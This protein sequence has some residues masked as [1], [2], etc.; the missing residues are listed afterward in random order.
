VYGHLE[1]EELLISEDTVV[2]LELRSDYLKK[3]EDQIMNNKN[4]LILS[5]IVLFLMAMPIEEV[6]AAQISSP[7][8]SLEKFCQEY[9]KQTKNFQKKYR[10]VY[11]KNCLK[12]N[13][14]VAVPPKKEQTQTAPPSQQ[15]LDPKKDEVKPPQ[16]Q[17]E[18]KPVKKR[19]APIPQQPEVKPA[20]KKEPEIKRP[21]PVLR[22]PLPETKKAPLPVVKTQQQQAAA[23]L[24]IAAFKAPASAK[25]GE[26]ISKKIQL[27]I[28]NQGSG[29]ATGSAL[30]RTKGYTVYLVLSR[31]QSVPVNVATQAGKFQEDLLLKGGAKVKTED[32]GSGEQFSFPTT[33]VVIPKDT[34]AGNY[35]LCARI[36]PWNRVKEINE[37]N[38]LTCIAISITGAPK[39]ALT[40]SAVPGPK[41]PRDD[42][43]RSMPTATPNLDADF[44]A[45][46]RD[47]GSPVSSAIE[48][49][50]TRDGIESATQP[51]AEQIRRSGS[52][53]ELRLKPD[54]I[55][56]HVE[57]R[58]EGPDIGKLYIEVTALTLLP[59][60]TEAFHW[61]I[62]GLA[63]LSGY[64]F[65]TPPE[66]HG[67]F[68]EGLAT[69]DPDGIARIL[70]DGR[71]PVPESLDDPLNHH[72]VEITINED[73]AFIESNYQNNT[74]IIRPL[75][76]LRTD[77][78]TRS[79]PEYLLE[80]AWV[81]SEGSSWA[82]LHI[83]YTGPSRE[84]GERFRF[85]WLIFNSDY[86]YLWSDTIPLPPEPLHCTDGLPYLPVTTPGGTG[87]IAR[88]FCQRIRFFPGRTDGVEVKM[89]DSTR[90][91][92]FDQTIF[93]PL[94]KEWFASP[95][96]MPDLTG[97]ITEVHRDI[98]NRRLGGTVSFNVTNI[99]T[100]T[101]RISTARIQ[102]TH[103]QREDRI[104]EEIVRVPSLAQ[105][106]S[107]G[108]T[109][110][111]PPMQSSMFFVDLTVDYDND[112]DEMDE[113]YRAEH[114]PFNNFTQTRVEPENE[115]TVLPRFTGAEHVVR[116]HEPMFVSLCD[117]PTEED[118][119][120]FYWNIMDTPVGVHNIRG[121]TRCEWGASH[122][123]ISFFDFQLPA[124]SGIAPRGTTVESATLEIDEIDVNCDNRTSL[125]AVRGVA[126]L[127]PG[128]LFGKVEKDSHTGF[129]ERISIPHHPE[130]SPSNVDV[131]AWVRGWIQEG[132]LRNSAIVLLGDDF[133]YINHNRLCGADTTAILKIRLREED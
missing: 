69:L 86:G 114:R 99:G 39:V 98:L 11:L 105:G 3:V 124:L 12:L 119:E 113:Y 40:D 79:R 56:T 2:L 107:Q 120:S 68:E 83:K 47:S 1:S 54:L 132:T 112:V 6:T 10:G 61:E 123:F 57:Q 84:T 67:R 110:D 35:N 129:T 53:Q 117:S 91:P 65:V 17:P 85:R 28:S 30:S 102:V 7:Q 115:I 74:L 127:D 49:A 96:R 31:D 18:V 22:A 109:L 111:V 36:D 4:L 100:A 103:F 95:P 104:W 128:W 48:G 63:E 15:A 9:S 21:I 90:Y 72:F 94:E 116:L 37:K 25:P 108:F 33:N 55:I 89:Q 24:V 71:L 16:N 19:P 46:V 52:V 101:A 14:P 41:T 32:L 122:T 64:R 126:L 27:S 34:P 58:L 38:N 42:P 62:R 77:R 81:E 75:N 97:E 130:T 44:S 51:Q 13:Q 92:E 43:Q 5:H 26:D 106:E 66:F 80:S 76:S 50:L 93:V 60:T 8:Q 29:T 23:D 133:R 121:S 131:T 88:Y 118:L 70:T 78:V 82:W 87:I 73:R 125:N 45:Q 20:E 59:S